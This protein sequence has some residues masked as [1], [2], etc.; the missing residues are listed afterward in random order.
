MSPARR[1]AEALDALTL[2][3]ACVTDAPAF[4][5]FAA[6]VHGGSPRVL[7]EDFSGSGAVARAWAASAPSRRS[8]AVDLDAAV[9][10]RASGRGVRAVR[11][12]AAACTV[13][14]DIITAT[15]F[16]LGY[17]HGRDGLVAYLRRALACLRPGGVF[18]ADTYGGSGAY[19]TGVTRRTVRLPGGGRVRYHWEQRSADPASG[20]V[21]DAIHF[22]IL[23][24]RGRVVRRLRD[25]FVYDWR[26]WSLPELRD[27]MGEAGMGTAEVYDRLGDAL[28]S[29]G[30]LYVRPK[31]AGE[32][33]E[34]DYVAYVV[35]RRGRTL[36]AR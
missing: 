2:Y 1:R 33:F 15:N 22:D 30:R 16:P 17:F 29:E 7:R 14:A 12:D 32:P 24:P 21:V 18:I 26:L 25:A 36:A 23:G 11:G 28:D 5:A 34:D 19:R 35:G 4:V 3:E 8:V 13:G 31:P 27:A 6:A 20:R 9:L 10:R